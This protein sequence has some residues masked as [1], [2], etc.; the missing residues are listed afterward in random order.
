MLL[1]LLVLFTDTSLHGWPRRDPVDPLHHMREVLHLILCEATLL[2]VLDPWPRLDVGNRV[3]ALVVACEIVA[4]LAGVLARQ[5]DLEDAK[6]AER[7][8]LEALNGV[9]AP[10]AAHMV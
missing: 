5:A 1:R 9:C 4:R 3:A 8:V 10:L 7:L 2:P 6:D